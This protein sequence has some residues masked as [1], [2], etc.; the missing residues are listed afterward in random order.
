[1]I[2][3]LLIFQSVD[4]MD[5]GEHFLVSYQ[6]PV[7]VLISE[8]LWINFV[9]LFDRKLKRAVELAEYDMGQRS[10]DL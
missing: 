8:I 5:I 1:M 2:W 3:D 6:M 10:R 9:E 7:I 4:D